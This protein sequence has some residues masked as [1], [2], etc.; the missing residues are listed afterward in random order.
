MRSR[1]AWVAGSSP[2]MVPKNK[3]SATPARRAL[4]GRKK[5]GRKEPSALPSMGMITAT[6]RSRPVPPASTAMASDSAST[7]P[8]TRPR[9]KPSVFSTASSLVR[10]RTAC[11]MVLPVTTS[12]M[13]K[14][15]VNTQRTIAPMLPT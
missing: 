5:T 1:M 14:T 8:S 2:A 7:S 12:M 3:I 10:S 6:A 11:A 15:A 9:E 4:G 13:R